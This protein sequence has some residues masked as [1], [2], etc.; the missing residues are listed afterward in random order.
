M[1]QLLN[2]ER[3]RRPGQSTETTII[4]MQSESNPNI[5]YRVDAIK[6]ECSCK[7]WTMHFPRRPCK[8][9]RQV[10]FK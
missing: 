7:G 4:T 6:G 1:A 5:S 8:H 2:A 3:V 10:G 9:L